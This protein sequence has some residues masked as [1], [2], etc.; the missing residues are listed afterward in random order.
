MYLMPPGWNAH[1]ALGYAKL[2]ESICSLFRS[3]FGERY[4]SDRPCGCCGG[5]TRVCRSE[6]EELSDRVVTYRECAKG[7][8]TRE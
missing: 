8:I 4:S 7:H 6:D 5:S 3:V 2:G 1:I